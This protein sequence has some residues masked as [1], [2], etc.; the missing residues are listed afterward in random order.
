MHV[1]ATAGGSAGAPRGPR[2]P[3]LAPAPPAVA[4]GGTRPPE[5]QECPPAVPMGGGRPPG[6]AI[7]R[8]DAQEVRDLWNKHAIEQFM[9]KKIY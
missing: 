1:L 5:R 2:A 4:M 3:G 6:A 9:A 7:R 8:R